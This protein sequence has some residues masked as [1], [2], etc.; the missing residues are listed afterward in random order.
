M[1]IKKYIL[2]VLLSSAILFSCSKNEVENSDEN[3]EETESVVISLNSEQEKN[4]NFEF[5]KLQE[6]EIQEFVNVTGTVEIPPE[7]RAKVSPIISAYV[8]QIFVKEGSPVKRGQTLA[9]LSHPDLIEL[10]KDFLECKND[11]KFYTKEYERQKKL[12]EEE[13]ESEKNLQKTEN[14]YENLKVKKE[15]LEEKLKLIGINPDKVSSANFRK[16]FALSSPIS[17]NVQDINVSIGELLSKEKTAFSILGN[18]HKH[19]EF[20]VFGKDIEKVALGQ[21]VT[22]KS[23]SFPDKEYLAVVKLI[24]QHVDADNNAVKIHGHIESKHDELMS[25]QFLHGKIQGIG[26]KTNAIPKSALIFSEEGNFVFVKS[27]KN[28]Y[29]K[30]FVETG[31]ENDTFVEVLNASELMQYDKI[32]SKGSNYLKSVGEG[33]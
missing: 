21:K 22:F 17:G 20:K 11:L 9:I 25:G 27:G 33:E 10:Q 23:S 16:T 32:V 7:N 28:Q 8:R 3:Q 12:V 30:V 24:S 14:T 13:A 15:Y 4:A 2:F 26:K 6:I 19:A 18:A 1:K 31:I 29:K 5:S